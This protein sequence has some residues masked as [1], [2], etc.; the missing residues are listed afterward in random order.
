MVDE[1]HLLE[2]HLDEGE[3]VGGGGD[4]A[5]LER[6]QQL[7][8]LALAHDV[9]DGEV[10]A[11]HGADGGEP[12]LAGAARVAG[13]NGEHEDD[14]DDDAKHKVRLLAVLFQIA[15][16]LGDNHGWISTSDFVKTNTPAP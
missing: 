6:G 9:G 2:G 1:A 7:E 11:V 4:G 13:A 12:V 3:G 10:G 14:G 5:V 16:E 15:V 8:L